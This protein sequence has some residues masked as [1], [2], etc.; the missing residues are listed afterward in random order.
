MSNSTTSKLNLQVLIPFIEEAIDL[1]KTN[2][3]ANKV[4]HNDAAWI[5]NEQRVTSAEVLLSLLR[6]DRPLS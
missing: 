5:E 4:L 1:E 2:L 3:E 6:R